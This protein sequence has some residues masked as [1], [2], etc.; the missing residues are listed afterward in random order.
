MS[1]ISPSH[2]SADSSSL[3]SN[4]SHEAPARDELESLAALAESDAVW[5]SLGAN[6]EFMPHTSEQRI[7]EIVGQYEYTPAAN[8]DYTRFVPQEI[9]EA[10]LDNV[11]EA[12]KL[13][14]EAKATE[15]MFGI[16]AATE[17]FEATLRKCLDTLGNLP[18][19]LPDPS[20]NFELVVGYCQ[21]RLGVSRTTSPYQTPESRFYKDGNGDF[22]ERDRREI[23]RELAIQ[24]YDIAL[25]KAVASKSPIEVE[26][27]ILTQRS[28]AKE[29]NGEYER[30]H[31]HR[32]AANLDF[33]ESVKDLET[34]EHLIHITETLKIDPDL[35][36]KIEEQKEELEA[37]GVL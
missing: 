29:L 11:D 20:Y 13:F 23:L 37:L 28:K 6:D 30:Q 36:R 32:I 16:E 35:P 14:E 1:E 26:A 19:G 22:Q 15:E 2:N 18:Q 17:S 34:A 7:V 31:G 5:Q 33:Q 10:Y 12:Y 8:E 27:I 3:R 21:S 4:G 9:V 25:T 24:S